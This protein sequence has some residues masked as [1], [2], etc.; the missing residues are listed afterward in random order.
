MVFCCRCS[1]LDRHLTNNPGLEH[2]YTGHWHAKTVDLFACNQKH[3]PPCKGYH[4]IV[5]FIYLFLDIILLPKR[6]YISMESGVCK[7]SFQKYFRC[8]TFTNRDIITTCNMPFQTDFVS[9][10]NTLSELEQVN[11]SDDNTAAP[12]PV[13]CSDKLVRTCFTLT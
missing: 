12:L 13:C 10:L 2:V 11:M 3:G 9:R 1:S 6:N 7:P 4:F 8:S 5:L